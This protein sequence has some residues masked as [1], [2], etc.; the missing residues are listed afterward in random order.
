MTPPLF[1]SVLVESLGLGEGLLVAAVLIIFVLYLWR[2]RKWGQL[3]VGMVGTAWLIAVAVALVVAAG[4]VLGWADP[5]P[6]AF[7]SDMA[8]A[9]TAFYDVVT[10]A[11]QDRLQGVGGG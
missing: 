9:A 4:I 1:V 3:L 2:G 5:N 7:I 8:A 6:G 10:G 11:I